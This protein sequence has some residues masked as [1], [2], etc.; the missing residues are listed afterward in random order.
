MDESG[1]VQRRREPERGGEESLGRDKAKLQAEIESRFPRGSLL[2]VRTWWQVSDDPRSQAL[3]PNTLEVRLIP[4]GPEAYNPYAALTP[5]EGKIPKDVYGP[6]A[7]D[8]WQTHEAVIQQL[9]RDLRTLVAE[10]VRIGVAYGGYTRGWVTTEPPL[11]PV[12]ARLDRTDLETLDALIAAGCAPNR[13]D[14]IRWA[15]ARVR[16]RPAYGQIAERVRELQT[17]RA[18]L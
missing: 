2:E 18:Q 11:T 5:G 16:E 14:A 8:F 17:L 1:A 6:V 3:E 10:R 9:G 13:A 12:M 4:R 7:N 15:L